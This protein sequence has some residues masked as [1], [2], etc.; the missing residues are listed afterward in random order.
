LAWSVVVGLTL[1][2]ALPWQR[3][4]LERYKM[5]HTFYGD[6]PGNF[7]GTGGDLFKRGWWLWLLVWPSV[8]LVIPLPFIYA[9]YKAIE[10]RWWI[11]GLRF[12]AV[13]ADCKMETGALIGLYWK[14][15]G[16]LTLLLAGVSV[17]V[18]GV[19]VLA[20]AY[21][22]IDLAA[23]SEQQ[24]TA[25]VQKPAVLVVAAA[26]YLIAALLF[27]VVTRL[28][29]TRDVW[30]RIANTT[31]VDHLAAAAN[32]ASRGDAASALGE[33]LADSLD[34]GGL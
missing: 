9:A 14:V 33:G 15:I 21:S 20:I 11:S 4:A 6:L 13:N 17:W 5:A 7:A 34:I 27:G 19:V 2:L 25:I 30:E 28:Y 18:T 12:G 10:W 22:G 31:S 3:A 29:L 24:I 1:G 32:V 23:A 26:G 8:F 16:W